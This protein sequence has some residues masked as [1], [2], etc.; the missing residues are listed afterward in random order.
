MKIGDLVRRK[1]LSTVRAANGLK[2]CELSYG[3]IVNIKEVSQP[4][5]FVDGTKL[6]TVTFP[7]TSTTHC[8]PEHYL[9][10]INEV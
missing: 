8:F 5:R 10:L 7:K 6:I 2:T 4:E 1:E 9:E 3:I